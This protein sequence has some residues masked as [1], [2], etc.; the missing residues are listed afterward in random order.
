MLTDIHSPPALTFPQLA[1]GGGVV[2]KIFLS[3]PS[4]E[5]VSGKV[6]F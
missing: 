5:E 1:W 6:L 4:D 3:N 2:S